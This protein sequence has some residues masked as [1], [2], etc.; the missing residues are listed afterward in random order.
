[1]KLIKCHS[2]GG[3]IIIKPIFYIH[4]LPPF[5]FHR[6]RERETVRRRVRFNAGECDSGAGGCDSG[7]DRRC[8]G[9]ILDP[10]RLSLFNFFSFDLFCNCFV[11]VVALAV[12]GDKEG[13]NGLSPSLITPDNFWGG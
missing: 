12:E 8:A 6:E 11:V 7:T 13:L 10:I 2:L 5:I 4:R 9:G 3:V 1:M